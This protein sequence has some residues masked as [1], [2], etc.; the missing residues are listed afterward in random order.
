VPADDAARVVGVKAVD[1][2]P[3]PADDPAADA[4]PDPDA[5]RPEDRATTCGHGTPWD[6]HAASVGEALQAATDAT[7]ALYI[8][9]LAADA[10][11]C[12]EG[13][14]LSATTRSQLQQCLDAKDAL[15]TAFGVL[16]QLLIDTAPA[17]KG[18]RARLAI[19]ERQLRVARIL[20]GDVA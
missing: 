7:E 8:R 18:Y 19:R 9:A 6:A 4:A 2:A 13:R 16:E 20:E 15:L 17:P 5:P 11:A 10:L 14:R 1:L 3:P 12:K